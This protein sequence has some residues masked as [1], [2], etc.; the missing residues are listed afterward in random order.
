M[1]AARC[2]APL[3]EGSL[4][5]SARCPCDCGKDCIGAKCVGE[6]GEQRRAR[7][8]RCLWAATSDAVVPY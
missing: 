3:H 2:V 6:I 8:Y 4:T 7:P 5:V 1:S